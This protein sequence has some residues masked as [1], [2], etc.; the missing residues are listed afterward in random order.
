M[1]TKSGFSMLTQLREHANETRA[2][3]L[4]LVPTSVGNHLATAKKE[5][6]TAVREVIDEE[7]KWTD[8]R[9]DAAKERKAAKKAARGATSSDGSSS[10]NA[11]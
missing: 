8:R 9:W 5:F 2:E 4:S 10:F 3:L 7:I 1:V 11:V 6:L